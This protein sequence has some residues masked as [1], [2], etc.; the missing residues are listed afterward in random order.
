MGA[1]YF[2]GSNPLG[3]LG[4]N[5]ANSAEIIQNIIEDSAVGGVLSSAQRSKYF[6]GPRC[7]IK[8]NGELAG[9]AF[10]VAWKID[11]EQKEIFTIDRWL[12]WEIAP[13]KMSVSG[14]LSMFHIP[15]QG[16]GAELIQS[17]ILSF[18]FFRY[19]TI[20]IQDGKTRKILFK[21]NKA[22]ITSRY[23][24]VKSETLSTI[25]LQWKAIGYTDE[26]DELKFPEGTA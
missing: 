12:P 11:T 25:Q 21:T 22:V 9:F 1:G 2:G 3:G 18:M 24:D 10:Q 4:I 14:T 16:P 20:E 6:T 8:I 13:V 5:G 26:N 15:G 7:I 23:Q 19:I 17:D